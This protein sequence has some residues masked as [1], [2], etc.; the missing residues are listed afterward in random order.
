MYSI[1]SVQPNNQEEQFTDGELKVVTLDQFRQFKKLDKYSDEEALVI[2]DSIKELTLI[3]HEIISS[4]E[5][6]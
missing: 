3:T 4:N 1:D 5:Q 6:S 2:I